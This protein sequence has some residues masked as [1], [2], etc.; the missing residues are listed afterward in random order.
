MAR[1]TFPSNGAAT[2]THTLTKWGQLACTSVAERSWASRII[3]IGQTHTQARPPKTGCR[4]CPHCAGCC[5]RRIYQNIRHITRRDPHPCRLRSP[6][7]ANAALT[8]YFNGVNL[9]LVD[10]VA[11][12]THI[13]T[14]VLWLQFGDFEIVAIHQSYPFV[15][16]HHQLRGRQHVRTATPQ[17]NQ[18]T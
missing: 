10:F 6:S 7:P 5:C 8:Q 16:R 9:V 14:G 17:Q 15:L 2:R 12:L 4:I 13:I 11:N 1:A 3:W 18:G